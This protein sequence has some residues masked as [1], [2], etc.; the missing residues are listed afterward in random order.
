MLNARRATLA[1]LTAIALLLGFV[2]PAGATPVATATLTGTVLAPN[3]QDPW[4]F[5]GS[6]VRVRLYVTSS[7][8][9]ESVLVSRSDGTYT[10]T[11]IV[12]GDYH[13]FFAANGPFLSEFSDGTFLYSQAAP[14]TFVAGETVTIDK[15]L[16]RGATI[17]GS[18]TGG[19]GRVADGTVTLYGGPPGFITPWAGRSLSFN[20]FRGTFGSGPLPPG[21]YVVRYQSTGYDWATQYSGNAWT[22]E[23]AVPITVNFGDAI[24]ASI[25]LPPSPRVSGRVIL[26]EGFDPAIVRPTVFVRG[27][28]GFFVPP[29]TISDSSGA[30]TVK[31]LQ[32]GPDYRLCLGGGDPR[33]GS[34]FAYRPTCYGASEAAPDGALFAGPRGELTGFDVNVELESAILYHGLARRNPTTGELGNMVNSNAIFWRFNPESG[35]WE[36]AAT[37]RYNSQNDDLDLLGT[38]IIEPGSY[39]IE[40]VSY[41]LGDRDLRQYNGGALR[42]IDAPIITVEP[43]RVTEV[44]REELI[45][46]EAFADRVAGSNRFDT[47][48][49]LSRSEFDDDS[50]PIVFIASGLNYPDALAAGPAAAAL[51]GPLLLVTPSSIPFVV[52]EELDRLNP[53][54]IVIVGGPASVSSS[55]QR[56]LE[57]FVSSAD[58]VVRLS[59]PDRYATS[60][61][62]VSEFFG[63]T[64]G[65]VV[66]VA[67]GANY[68]DALAAGPAASYFGG[69]VVLVNGASSTL[70]APTR[71]LLNQLE[72]G[73]IVIA[74]GPGVVS[75]GIESQLRTLY[76]D[77]D[78][79]VIR[80]FGPSRYETAISINLLI[81]ETD[82]A[83]L[84]TGQGFAD[85]LAAGPIA[86]MN[87][88]PLYLARP[89][90]VPPFVLSD[91]DDLLIRRVVAVGGTGVLSQAVLDGTSC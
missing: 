44:P 31:G 63:E 84:A 24:D 26:P 5:D 7:S 66:F 74:G 62:V 77:E 10:I 85:A 4:A 18:M 19:G 49:Q 29:V 81:P 67:T 61:A 51:G 8:W 46:P 14:V 86:G 53:R 75:S 32:V 71:G 3:G 12:P 20:A 41:G 72:P 34:L 65:R 56:Q 39:R 82:S 57:A 89:T 68:P 38:P 87:G 21:E 91:L 27:T 43:G 45:E 47:A 50:Q 90:C 11:G 40:V 9:V 30:F 83:Y 1:L 78:T 28:S 88:A 36:E 80:L 16:N 79:P 15:T 25:D 35:R 59:G 54:E 13:V 60:R 2:T 55:V 17:S 58:R 23:E 22:V 64:T 76:Q 33:N 73:L 42:F 48:V 70:D 52:A 6:S 69:A 37:A